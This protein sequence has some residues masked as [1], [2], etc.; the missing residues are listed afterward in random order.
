MTKDLRRKVISVLGKYPKARESDAWLTIKIWCEFYPTK[1]IREEGKPPMI[2]L[3]D[4]L[5]LP[6]ED[7]CKRI[8]AVLQN[9][10]H[11]FLPADPNVRRQRKIS[12]DTWQKFLQ[13]H[14]SLFNK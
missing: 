5:T 3:D 8:R 10:E 14:E 6:K 11:R 13:G 12:E 2:A 7:H 9:D 1:V 4:I